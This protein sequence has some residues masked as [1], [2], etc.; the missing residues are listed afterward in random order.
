MKRIIEYS[1][2]RSFATETLEWPLNKAVAP[3]I[4]DDGVQLN[5]DLIDA[6]LILRC[7]LYGDSQVKT[8]S[9]MVTNC[10]IGRIN[11]EYGE[12][13]IVECGPRRNDL[14][15]V[16][17][18]YDIFKIYQPPFSSIWSFEGATLSKDDALLYRL[19]NIRNYIYVA[20]LA[21]IYILGENAAFSHKDKL[22]KFNDSIN[23]FRDEINKIEELYLTDA[24]TEEQYNDI[25][26]LGY[27]LSQ[28]FE[29]L[30]EENVFAFGA[31]F[32]NEEY[33]A[34]L[35]IEDIFLSD[36]YSSLTLISGEFAKLNQLNEYYSRDK[37]DLSS[38]PFT[39]TKFSKEEKLLIPSI[40]ETHMVNH[41][42]RFITS[43][44]YGSWQNEDVSM[45][46]HNILLEGEAG[47]G[48][49][50]LARVLAAKMNRPFLSFSCST[51]TEESDLK[52]M[53]LPCVDDDDTSKMDE[54]LQE[55]YKIIKNSSQDE[56]Y[57]NIGKHLGLPNF[58]DI[59][60][61][62]TESYNIMASAYNYPSKPHVDCFTA[63]S[64]YNDIV[65][66]EIK[67]LVASVKQLKTSNSVSYKYLESPILR[68]IRNGYVLELQEIS[69]VKNQGVF[70]CLF[71]VLERASRGTVNTHVGEVV[72]HPDFICI[73]TTNVGYAGC[74]P[75]N[76][77]LR[78]RFQ[79]PVKLDTPTNKEVIERLKKR[80]NLPDETFSKIVD[81]FSIIRDTAKALRVSGELTMRS[82][83]QFTDSFSRCYT[84]SDV[85]ELIKVY[86]IYSVTTD[87]EEVTELFDKALTVNLEPL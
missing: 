66:G 5:C 27:S 30:I 17:K 72:R 2:Q 29:E 35:D 45:H 64:L 46:I 58:D 53:L 71:D 68:A 81:V 44:V 19:Q 40:P 87:E 7:S 1:Y 75:L 77:A 22:T 56:M 6:I 34:F 86:L 74:K 52:G 20:I 16:D 18:N 57:E 38:L 49:S 63:I 23:I 59:E 9:D 55:L 32:P 47:S 62:P 8:A 73:A 82:L 28:Q 85:R 61:D 42:E 33:L 31:C 80:F 13:I 21:V 54:R 39:K 69:M 26:T 60:I 36:S 37:V 76:Q 11:D 67:N 83:F 78:S 84:N 10:A 14:L 51:N 50:Q 12:S 4:R 41:S 43:Q 24:V 48:K 3:I 25:F 65:S 70:T 15:E 79:L